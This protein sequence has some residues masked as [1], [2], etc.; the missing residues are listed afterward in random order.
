MFNVY[1]EY[2]ELV[3]ND[4]ETIAELLEGLGYKIEEN[5]DEQ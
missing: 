3:A 1:N 5:E 2:D 4:M